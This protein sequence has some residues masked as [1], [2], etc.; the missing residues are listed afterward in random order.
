MKNIR[1]LI[2]CLTMMSLVAEVQAQN[3]QQAMRAIYIQDY[4]A[5]TEIIQSGIDVNQKTRGSYLLHAACL[6]GN[7]NLVT[8]LLKQG[9]NVNAIADDGTSALFWAARSDDNGEIVTMLLE[10]GARVNVKNVHGRTPFDQ[11]VYR[12]IQDNGNHAVMRILLNYG[13]NIDNTR[14]K[15]PTSGYTPL[16]AATRNNQ[17][18]LVRFLLDHGANINHIAEDGNTPLMIAADEGNLKMVELFIEHGAKT[19][20]S[21]NDGKTALDIAKAKSYSQLVSFLKNSKLP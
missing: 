19:E 13:A 10:K 5:A 21:N 8:L 6:R 17:I 4:D 18:K 11:A 14:E 12:S 16:M 3:V 1:Y 7:P 20:F 15:G 2:V 9:A